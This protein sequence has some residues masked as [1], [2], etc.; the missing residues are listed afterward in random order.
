MPDQD[1]IREIVQKIQARNM[2]DA[3]DYA[4]K[5]AMDK[6]LHDEIADF[7][8]YIGV[9]LSTKKQMHQEALSFF[10]SASEMAK[11]EEIR[12]RAIENCS[13]AHTALG[14]MLGK[15][16]DYTSSEIHFK[17][18]LKLNPDLPIAHSGYAYLLT[19]MERYDEAK[20]HFKE[21]F[22]I[23]P[24]DATTHFN[25]AILLEKL[26]RYNEMILHCGEALRLDPKNPS[27]HIG[28][29]IALR[30]HERFD[31][32][33]NHLKE[34]LRI[35]PT[36][37]LASFTYGKLLIQLKRFSEAKECFKKT[38]EI[39]P[40]FPNAS[41]HHDYSILMEV[42]ANPRKKI[43]KEWLIAR[44]RDFERE[45]P[46]DL[47]DFGLQRKHRKEWKILYENFECIRCGTCCKETNWVSNI[48][49]RIPWEDIQRWRRE[50]RT[51]ILEKVY[52]YEGLGGDLFDKKT[53]RRFSKCPF[54]KKK[55]KIYSCSIHKT[56]P[57]GC[58]LFPFYFNHQG[59]CEY[60]ESPI[61]ED[62]VFCEECGLF[63][64]ASPVVHRCPGLKKT[65]K[66]LGLYREMPTLI[67]ELINLAFRKRSGND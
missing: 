34:A 26:N 45:R 21:A 44:K 64:K 62:D 67:S 33:E 60:C 2:Q 9:T 50:G 35:S 25:Y 6:G 13:V 20:S 57:L 66:S 30:H 55:G 23:K 32:A 59:T 38:L 43:T 14:N 11:S 41:I 22:R 1:W 24:E 12:K 27:Y 42:S 49:L 29:A 65:L 52:V 3:L 54:L 63:L 8:T 18:A 15:K 7:L 39:D 47:R 58:K 56:K 37:A 31:E 40:K 28:Y 19:L 53:F 16:G 17:Q 48:E 46:G 51:D 10:E 5:A 61:D 4:R 36:L